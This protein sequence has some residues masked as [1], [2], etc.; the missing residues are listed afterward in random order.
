MAADPVSAPGA[1]DDGQ[2][3]AERRWTA[4]AAT[5]A[6]G[7]LG[8]TLVWWTLK[9]GAYYGRVL[10]PGVALLGL[11]AIV[12]LA[13]APWRAS[14][15]VSGRARL[16]LYALLAL[17]AWSLAS[18]L[19]SPTPDIA[20]EDAQRIAGYA[21]FFGL[22]IWG[23]ALL[24]RRMEL[25]VVPV[26]GAAGIAALI[27]LIALAGADSPLSYLEDD[28]TFQ[29]PLGY[30]NANAAF[31]LIALWPSL[32]LAGSPRV[33]RAVRVGAF[34][35][36]SACIQ[37]ALLAQSRGSIVAAG[38]ALVVYL[39]VARNR[40]GALAWLALAMV[41]AAF[42]VFDAVSLF[43]AAKG[44]D[45]LNGAVDE[46]NSA[47][48]SGL[49]RLAV[50]AAI[51][52]AAIHFEPRIKIARTLANRIL[53]AGIVV[54]GIGF[55]VAVGNPF[56][57]VGDRAS[58][59]F[60]GEADLSESSSRLTFNAGSNRSEIWRV[61]LEVSGDDPIFGQ[62]GG[63]F[64]YRFTQERDDP[65]Q[66]ARDAHSVEL[67]MLTE[68]G[69]VGL[70]LFVMVLAGAFAGAIGAR[71]LGPAAA[72]LSCG[73]LAAGAYWLTHTSID[74]FWPYPAVT[75]A[76]FALLGAAVAPTLLMPE[77]TSRPGGRRVVIAVIAVF[78]VSLVPPLLSD[79]LVERSFNTF[80]A[81]TEQAY[82]DLDMARNLNPL[83]DLPALSEGS[84][85]IALSDR[86]RAIE[87]YREAIRQRPEEY[88]GHFFLALLYSKTDPDKARTE[89]AVVAE[90]NPLEPRIDSIR[91]RIE[92][93]ERS[94]TPGRSGR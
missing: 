76:T 77:R 82:D 86:E 80:R 56:T 47:G 15:A 48:V 36:A 25:A 85:A 67:E 24:G 33:A 66:L 39:V 43:D 61:A 91:K 57:W 71:K 40:L 6:L 5:L 58:E 94:A 87:A 10:Y 4:I 11:G 2:G 26:V 63:G 32:A 59:F 60:D 64:Q 68:L 22:A 1:S 7:L 37:I 21:L 81:D 75:A 90:L 51:C 70:V 18:A 65:D 29:Y 38:V 35:T 55:I 79:L 69:G 84:I 62:G 42:T 23:C 3:R 93:A 8:G 73:A 12:L 19:W 41:P 52:L 83:S 46:M 54:V 20:V 44:G 31:F 50:A 14:L 49:I 34:V 27:G 30:R 13:T 9:D 92:E 72:Q 53:V 17:A 16:A 88:A 45:G 28:G 78:V 74:W 89:L